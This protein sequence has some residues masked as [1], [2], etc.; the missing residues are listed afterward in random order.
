LVLIRASNKEYIVQINLR[1]DHFSIADGSKQHSVER[2]LGM[3]G[4][5]I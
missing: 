2:M 3:S 1:A 4:R 5:D